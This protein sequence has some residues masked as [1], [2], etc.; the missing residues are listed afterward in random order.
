VLRSFVFSD[1]GGNNLDYCPDTLVVSSKDN[2]ATTLPALAIDASGNLVVNNT[3]TLNS[4]IGKP[5]TFTV[6]VKDKNGGTGALSFVLTLT[7]NVTA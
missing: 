5:F 4:R 1:P 2:S 3:T 7:I 6:T